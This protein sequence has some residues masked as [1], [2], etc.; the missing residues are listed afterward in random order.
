M[1]RYLVWILGPLVGAGAVAA[2]SQ[3]HLLPPDWWCLPWLLSL[4]L[5]G[6]PHGALDHAVVLH[7]W[8]PQPPPAW[9]LPVLLAGYLGLVVFVLAL[10]HR[11]PA[12]LFLGFILLTWNHWGLA[13]L[14]WSWQRDPGYFSST[15][16]RALFAA[17]RGGLPM[18]LPLYADPAFYQ[19][20][21]QAASGLFGASAA[22]FSWMQLPLMRELA[23]VG[24]L[25]L[26]AT[27][28]I[29]ARHSARTYWVNLLEGLS[30][31]FF[32]VVLPALVSLGLYFT[33]WHGL[34]H[35]LRLKRFEG[36]SWSQLIREAWP[37][38][39]GALILLIGLAALTPHQGGYLP[40]L[41]IYLVLISALT[42]PHALVVGWMDARDG[43]WK[44]R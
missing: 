32:F 34:R 38:T 20:T 19:Q 4:V 16:H 36:G 22:A 21:A 13:D 8:R 31:A 27:E 11:Q 7:L 42:V 1:K 23:L 25:A 29:L 44:L 43:L 6:L 3:T 28:F 40:L 5:F 37:A 12:L 17:W 2:F 9:A 14:W 33:F 35:V 39:V 15:L 26:G 41:A 30:L 10:W 18:L 24:T